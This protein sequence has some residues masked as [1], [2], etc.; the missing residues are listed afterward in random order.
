MYRYATNGSVMNVVSY[1]C[2]RLLTWSAINVVCNDRGL[3]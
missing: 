1:E 3:L 2:G